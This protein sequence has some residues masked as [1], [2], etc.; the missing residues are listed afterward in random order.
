MTDTNLPAPHA[1]NLPIEKYVLAVTGLVGFVVLWYAS[2]K[3]LPIDAFNRLPDP[4]AVIVEWTSPDPDYGISIFTADYYTHIF[5]STYRALS[6][7]VLAV[8]LGV[9]LGIFMGWKK[10]VHNYAYSLLG[11]LRPVPPLAW[12]PIAILL[13]PGVE[14][15]V[16]FVTFLVAFFATTMNTLVGVKAIPEDYFRAAACFGASDRDILR[17]IVIPGAMPSIF[18]G[19][20][21]AMGAAWFSL[22][23]GEMI[24]AQYGLGFIIWEAYNLIQYPTIVIGMATLGL[25][26][27]VSSMLVRWVGKRLMVW[28]EQKL[29][30]AG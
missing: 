1:A 14:L 17:D 21:I 5:Y 4:L 10:S 13:F 8:V 9:P 22:A 28:H 25:V 12:V 26:G 16:I 23:A 18:T 6:A 11:L 30:M 2:V 3:W 27:Y 20:Q 19:L 15:A 24:A 7:F 29:G